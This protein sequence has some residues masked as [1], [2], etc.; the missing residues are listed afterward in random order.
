MSRVRIVV[1]I[2]AVIVII[3]LCYI[4]ITG[5]P[6]EEPRAQEEANHI[7]TVDKFHATM[8]E[9]KMLHSHPMPSIRKKTT[10]YH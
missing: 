7:V 9:A 10:A 5:A 3:A 2:C 1:D 6:D 4:I 8:H